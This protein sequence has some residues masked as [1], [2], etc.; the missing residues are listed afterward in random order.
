ME[1]SRSRLSAAKIPHQLEKETRIIL[2]Y[3]IQYSKLFIFDQIG[4]IKS[5][6]VFSLKVKMRHE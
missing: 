1:A 6:A 2:C 5:T 3:Q 4:K